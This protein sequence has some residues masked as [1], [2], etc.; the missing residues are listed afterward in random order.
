M[1]LY[2]YG[3]NKFNGLMIKAWEKNYSILDDVKYCWKVQ[4]ESKNIQVQESN[5]KYKQM[6]NPEV[7]FVEPSL[8]RFSKIDHNFIRCGMS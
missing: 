5:P 6:D 7:G 8:K 3:I 4:H 2:L 1:S